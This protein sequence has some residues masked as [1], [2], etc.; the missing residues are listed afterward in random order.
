MPFEMGWTLGHVKRIENSPNTKNWRV[1]NRLKILLGCKETEGMPLNS[2][3]L[4]INIWDKDLTMVM[5]M[6]FISQGPLIFQA[7][8]YPPLHSPMTCLL[9]TGTCNC[10]GMVSILYMHIVQ[11]TSRVNVTFYPWSNVVQYKSSKC[12]YTSREVNCKLT[13]RA[14]FSSF[15]CST[16]WKKKRSNGTI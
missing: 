1:T 7:M 14:S 6:T 11:E 2:V 3:S 4:I 12:F 5:I 8:L 16:F 13:F 10:I 15:S 9:H